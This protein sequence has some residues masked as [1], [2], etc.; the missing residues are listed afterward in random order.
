MEVFIDSIDEQK[1]R[2]P[3]RNCLQASL[4]M[5][6]PQTDTATVM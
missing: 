1:A 6:S 2:I 3:I 4:R 5:A